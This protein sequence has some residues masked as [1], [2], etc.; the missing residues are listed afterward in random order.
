MTDTTPAGGPEPLELR[1]QPER[2]WPARTAGDDEGWPPKQ[3]GKC[4][5]RRIVGGKKKRCLRAA[6]WGT[7]H[8]GYGLCKGDLGRTPAAK[9]NAV[10][11]EY[12][13]TMAGRARF[14]E[15][16]DIDPFMGLLNEIGR[17]AGFMAHVQRRI[18]ATA[19]EDGDPVLTQ[20][21]SAGE[22]P[23][24]LWKILVEERKHFAAVCKMA[25]DAGIGKVTVDLVAA[26][27]SRFLDI[28]E[29]TL[30]AAGVDPDAPE[31]SAAIVRHLALIPP[32]AAAGTAP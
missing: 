10:R 4:N 19:G 20:T 6:G 21:T 16:L 17:T 29:A 18:A 12:R 22:I 1:G 11:E 15:V 2:R 32:D 27:Q 26:Y 23:S 3:P 7:D 8:P 5:A 25:H 9:R 30:R 14:G 31:V 28:L 13:T 24:A